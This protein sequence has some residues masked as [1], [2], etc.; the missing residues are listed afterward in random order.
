[1]PTQRQIQRQVTIPWCRA[2]ETE[3]GNAHRAAVAHLPALTSLPGRPLSDQTAKI[4]FEELEQGCDPLLAV[5]NLKVFFLHVGHH[6][7]D[8]VEKNDRKGVSSQHGV[9]Q[10]LF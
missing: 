7:F 9:D 3:I 5:Y 2:C 4:T 10:L 8:M 1:V 6:F